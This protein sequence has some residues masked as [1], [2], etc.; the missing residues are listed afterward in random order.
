MTTKVMETRTCGLCGGKLE[1]F[2]DDRCDRCWEMETRITDNPQLAQ[3]I[4]ASLVMQS[5][6]DTGGEWRVVYD[7]ATSHPESYHIREPGNGDCIAHAATERDA[8][9]IVSDHNAVVKLVES[10]E[11][12]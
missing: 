11:S 6:P 4:L 3:R 9:Q 8:A 5:S 2:H 1:D 7:P 10:I 12:R